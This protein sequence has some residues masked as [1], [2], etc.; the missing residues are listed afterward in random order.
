MN[1]NELEIQYSKRATR[2]LDNNAEIITKER[3]DLLVF[4]AV[5]KLLKIENNNIDLLQLHGQPK[6][7][8]RVKTGRIRII[9]TLEKEIIYIAFVDDVA[10][11][12]DVYR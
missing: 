10:F 1:S 8:F 2:F 4:S 6:G 5:K 12:K 11:R 3:A 7:T 9:F